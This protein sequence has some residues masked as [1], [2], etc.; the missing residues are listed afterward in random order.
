VWLRGR[1]TGLTAT[2]TATSAHVAG[3]SG[4]TIEDCRISHD[5]RCMG[6]WCIGSAMTCAPPAGEGSDGAWE[7]TVRAGASGWHEDRRVV[8][9]VV[10]VVVRKRPRA[11]HKHGDKHQ[12]WADQNRRHRVEAEAVTAASPGDVSGG[13]GGRRRTAERHGNETSRLAL[14]LDIAKSRCPA[15]RSPLLPHRNQYG[16]R[17]G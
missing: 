1:R 14:T 17:C 5:R 13:R 15:R 16:C 6:P 3:D 2:L 9:L 12:Q 7:W 10:L 11:R 4:H 8:G